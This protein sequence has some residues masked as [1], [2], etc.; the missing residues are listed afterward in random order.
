MFYGGC[1]G[2]YVSIL[3]PREDKGVEMLGNEK[4]LLGEI[5]EYDNCLIKAGSESL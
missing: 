2:D 3:T 5:G 1:R 4:E